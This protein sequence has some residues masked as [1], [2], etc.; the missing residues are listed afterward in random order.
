MK[1]RTNDE[2]RQSLGLINGQQRV[3]SHTSHNCRWLNAKGE[4]IGH[5]DLTLKD[6]SNISTR[7][8]CWEIFIVVDDVSGIENS[9]KVE[10]LASRAKFIIIRGRCYSIISGVFSGIYACSELDTM[11]TFEI[12]DKEKAKEIISQFNCF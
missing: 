7:I 1:K 11:L 9:D 12:I 6:F 10:F 2:I 5:G 3:S 8:G 4:S